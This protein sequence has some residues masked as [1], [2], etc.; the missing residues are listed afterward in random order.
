MFCK[1]LSK[2]ERKVFELTLIA[3]EE[4]NQWRKDGKSHIVA[5]QI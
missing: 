2:Y 1:K 5:A 4:K 3:L